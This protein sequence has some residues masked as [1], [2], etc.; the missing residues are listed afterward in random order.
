MIEQ[1]A[2]RQMHEVGSDQIGFWEICL[3]EA[4]I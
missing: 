1:A 4:D 3:I 2:Q